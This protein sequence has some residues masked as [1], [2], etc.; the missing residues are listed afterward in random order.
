M[1]KRRLN[2]VLGVVLAELIGTLALC[3][4]VDPSK[5]S[6]WV[7]LGIVGGGLSYLVL[8]TAGPISLVRKRVGTGGMSRRG[9]RTE[10]M[11]ARIARN[12]NN[13]CL[14]RYVALIIS[15]PLLFLCL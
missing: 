11:M 12:N 7:S 10:R 5:L 3:A 4:F 2:V 1:Q 8:F 14:V 13:K 9:L 15:G 6:I